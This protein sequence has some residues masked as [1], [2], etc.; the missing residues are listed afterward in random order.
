MS[1]RL[2]S[3]Q[4]GILTAVGVA[5]SAVCVSWG[6]TQTL[7]TLA[8]VT[9]PADATNGGFWNR[10]DCGAVSVDVAEASNARPLAMVPRT[11]VR[12]GGLSR[13]YAFFHNWLD[14]G[15]LAVSFDVPGMLLFFR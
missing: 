8:S 7:D 2:K 15:E 14:C 9:N 5:L 4:R 1:I 10:T 13:S 6:A 11:E 3:S 12:S